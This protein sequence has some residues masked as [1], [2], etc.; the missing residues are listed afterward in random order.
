M[1]ESQNLGRFRSMSF[2]ATAFAILGFSTSALAQTT[3]TPALEPAPEAKPVGLEPAATAE[4]APAA[5]P[6][7]TPK[8]APEAAVETK[9]DVGATAAAKIEAPAPPAALPLTE[10]EQSWF[11]RPGLTATFGTGDKALSLTLYGFLQADAMYDTT[12]SY[13]DYIG[14]SLVAPTYTLAG[15]EGRAQFS[16]RNTRIGLKFESPKFGGVKT[17]AV[18]EGDFFGNQRNDPHPITSSYETASETPQTEAAYFNNPAFR[19]RHAYVKLEN[20]Y[21]DVL[22]GQTYDVFGWQNYFYPA[23]VQYLGL[24]NQVFSRSTQF[25]LSHAFGASGPVT[26]E[27]AASALRPAQRDSGV[28]DANGGLRVG[29]NGW[30]GITTPGNTGT[31]ALP[32]SIGVSG[33]FRQFRPNAFT[34]APIQKADSVQAWGLSI[35][36][37][38]PI[39]P[40]KNA[41]DRGNKLTLTGGFVTGTGIGD[42]INAT[43]GAAFPTLP[44]PTQATPEPHYVANVDPG[45][46]SIGTDGKP[47]T[48]DWS[49]FRAGIQYY[50]PGSGRI[51]VSANYTQATSKNMKKFF[52]KGGSEIEFLVRVADLSR[53][54]DVNLFWDATPAVRFG[55]SGQY[56]YVEYLDGD[57]PDN[58]RGMAQ[59][60][61][62]F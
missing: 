22:A 31:T 32:L 38:L 28:P 42:L 45:I 40:A 24:P 18:F 35:D 36:A 21:V 7:E 8:V 57:K 12:R 5:A 4:P 51:L 43:G 3:T 61:Y 33:T 9:V 30:K 47:Y 26:V 17:T 20:D 55:L 49:A 15:K 50:L 27:V 56:S 1:K 16:A 14:N 46:L 41:F 52:P 62:A 23:S 29:L 58:L 11:Y 2:T 13:N 60:L 59:A 19:L 34:P 39:I 53:Y 6:A 10:E 54:A 37:L 48:I 25:R 44:N